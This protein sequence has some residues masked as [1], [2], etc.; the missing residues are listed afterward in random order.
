M[1]DNISHYH[2]IVLKQ[3]EI[4]TMF[5]LLIECS[6]MLL[7]YKISTVNSLIMFSVIIERFL[8]VG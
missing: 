1:I 6:Q 7:F 3:G 2:F 5:I 4:D 8:F